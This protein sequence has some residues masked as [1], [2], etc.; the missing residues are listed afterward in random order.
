MPQHYI[1]DYGKVLVGYDPHAVYDPYFGDRAKTDWFLSHILTEQVSLRADAGEDLPSLIREL[2]AQ[3]PD[4]AEAIALYDTRFCDMITGEIEGM[5]Q[6][7]AS[8][9]SAGHRLYGLTNWSQKVYQVMPRYP[10]FSLLDGMV[11]SSDVH[12][13]KPDPRIYQCLLDKYDL[14]PEDCIFVDD[15]PENVAAARQLGMQGHVFTSAAELQ[16]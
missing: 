5:R 6:L 11:V 16:P 15:R 1:F 10:I 2:Q 3:Y 4:Y 8:L 9:K 14:R 12:L 13:V 7:L